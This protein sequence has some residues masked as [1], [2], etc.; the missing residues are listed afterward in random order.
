MYNKGREI[1]YK[2]LVYIVICSWYINGFCSDIE[3]KFY[4]S[5]FNNIKARIGPSTD[6]KI[7][8]E[9]KGKHIPFKILKEFE[10][11]F[12]IEDVYGDSGWIRKN[13][14]SKEQYVFVVK[15]D[16]TNGYKEDS[17][18][19]ISHFIEKYALLKL[20]KCINNVCKLITE[21]KKIVWVQKENLWGC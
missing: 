21:D 5:K 14:L 7:K 11:W 9:Y 18:D 10:G 15:S 6:F 1:L 17:C 12:E 4:S 13:K 2:I 20:E 19:N 8:Y 3:G 16:L